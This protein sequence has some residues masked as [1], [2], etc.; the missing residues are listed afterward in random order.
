MPRVR[1]APLE[2]RHRV[3]RDHRLTGPNAVLWTSRA[4]ENR[5]FMRLEVLRP[6]CMAL[7]VDADFQDAVDA[8]SVLDLLETDARLRERHPGVAGWAASLAHHE[9]I[10]RGRVA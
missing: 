1:L 6:E 9:A 10:A 4:S 2:L 3:G 5:G 7:D 8:L